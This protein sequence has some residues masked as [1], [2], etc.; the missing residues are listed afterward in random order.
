MD[1]ETK[2][3][4]LSKIIILFLYVMQRIKEE[5]KHYMLYLKSSNQA[6]AG[7]EAGKQTLSPEEA[8]Q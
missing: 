4:A 6:M 1:K 5:P 7:S 2:E 3:Y 8:P